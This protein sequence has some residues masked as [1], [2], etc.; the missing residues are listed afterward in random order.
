MIYP[1]VLAWEQSESK[2]KA[3]I[4]VPGF[5]FVLA[6][7]NAG[8]HGTAKIPITTKAFTAIPIPSAIRAFDNLR[9]LVLR[10]IVRMI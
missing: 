8:V 5:W 9:I 4:R 6:C 10:N 3:G 1:A 2:L 7:G